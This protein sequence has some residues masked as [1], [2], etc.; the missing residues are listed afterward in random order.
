MFIY[1]E[2][3]PGRPGHKCSLVRATAPCTHS[4]RLWHATVSAQHV[5][6]QSLSL[7][8]YIYREREIDMVDFVQTSINIV[9]VIS[10]WIEWYRNNPPT[11]I[12]HFLFLTNGVAMKDIDM[13]LAGSLES[14]Q[15][16]SS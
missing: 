7:Y 3:R 13:M 8:I 16:A 15:T 6:Q 11:Y 12:H 10:T 2:I 4:L 5:Q 9:K 14:C 1:S